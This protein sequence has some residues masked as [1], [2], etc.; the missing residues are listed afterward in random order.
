[1]RSPREEGGDFTGNEQGRHYT[2]WS[3]QLDLGLNTDGR[4]EGPQCQQGAQRADTEEVAWV[5]AWE[6]VK[7]LRV[8]VLAGLAL[9]P[10]RASARGRFWTQ[11]WRWAELVRGVWS[12]G[13]SE[14][15]RAFGHQARRPVGDGC[16]GLG[17]LPTSYLS[18]IF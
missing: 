10:Q 16:L 15:G 13:E 1:L 11:L 17:L 14:W 9:W 2:A 4:M 5:G 12:Q 7:S 3:R 6:A 18:V 8:A